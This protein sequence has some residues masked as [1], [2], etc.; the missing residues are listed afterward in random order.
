MS[1]ALGRKGLAYA[2]LGASHLVA[3]QMLGLDAGAGPRRVLLDDEGLSTGTEI[4]YIILCVCL[5]AISGL[6]AGL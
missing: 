3:R 2:A 4:G 5:V 6:A 1:S